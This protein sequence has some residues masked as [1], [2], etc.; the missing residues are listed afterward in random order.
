MNAATARDDILDRTYD[1]TPDQFE[2]LCRILIKQ[3]ERTRELELTPR[4]GDDGIDVHAVIDRNLFQARLGVQAK[5]NDWNNTISSDT[6]RLF[7]GSLDE[8]GYDIGSFITTSEYTDPAIK[9]AEK[10]RIRIID[11]DRLAEI[12]LQSELGVE[13]DSDGYAIDWDFWEIFELEGEDDLVRSD[14]VPQAD[15]VST[16]NIVLCGIDKGY[17]VKPTTT[18]FLEMVTG[19]DWDPRQADYY[20]H[21]AWPLGFVHKDTTIEYAGYE[22][23]R[24]TLSRIG[25]EYVQ[26]L[27]KDDTE[28]AEQLLFERIREMEIAKRVLNPLERQQTLKFEELQ[29]IIHQNTLPQG[30]QYGL[31]KNTAYRRARTIGRWIEKLPEVVRHAPA[32]VRDDQLKG[33]TFE[34]LEKR[35]TDY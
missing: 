20:P 2:Q 26:Y 4:S 23:R 8:G 15:T 13:V 16:L 3:S 27:Y 10:G 32:G 12:M 19:Y 14:A 31:S 6:M 11:G 22:R 18:D 21:A 5:R 7:K 28:S 29:E 30:H 17:D 33:S 9:S 34:Y 1:I 24:W 25:R 35:L